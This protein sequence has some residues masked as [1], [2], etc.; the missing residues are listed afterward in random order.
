MLSELYHDDKS[1]QTIK[2]ELKEIAAMAKQLH[3]QKLITFKHNKY[4]NQTIQIYWSS[5][6]EFQK[7]R[8]DERPHYSNALN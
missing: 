1:K 4:M 2:C 7:L 3:L 5:L 8:L 6:D